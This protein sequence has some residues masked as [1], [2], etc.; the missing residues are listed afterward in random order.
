M[1]DEDKNED[2]QVVNVMADTRRATRP[3]DSFDDLLCN[4][5]KECQ[6]IFLDGYA[7]CAICQQ[8]GLRSR[9]VACYNLSRRMVG[10]LRT[11]AKHS[12]LSDRVHAMLMTTAGKKALT[13]AFC[14]NASDKPKRARWPDFN[15]EAFFANLD[16]QTAIICSRCQ[17]RKLRLHFSR[18]QLQKPSQKRKCIE[19]TKPAGV[20]NLSRSRCQQ[21]KIALNGLQS[22]MDRRPSEKV[23]MRFLPSTREATGAYGYISCSYCQNVKLRTEFSHTQIHR[24]SPKRKCMQ[25]TACET[26]PIRESKSYI[27]YSQ[28]QQAK[29]RSHLIHTQVD[30]PA[31]K[32]NCVGSQGKNWACGVLAVNEP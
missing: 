11:Q 16:P 29:P 32:R 28:C 8:P 22:Q 4:H 31:S 27:S 5:W 17:E 2:S 15:F 13:D 19:C 18:T 21:T 3:V 26:G 1:P 12:I 25:C 24:P 30:E 6:K 10:N 7:G 9:C 23:C 14:L 20:D